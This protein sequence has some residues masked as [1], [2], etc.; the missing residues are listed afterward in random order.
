MSLPVVGRMQFRISSVLQNFDTL[1]P[2][3][4]KKL[5][6][7]FFLTFIF[8]LHIRLMKSILALFK[9]TGVLPI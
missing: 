4:K 8:F 3:E 1:N 9:T 7:F 5:Q 6:R 2:P